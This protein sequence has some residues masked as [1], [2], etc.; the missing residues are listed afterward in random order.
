[1]VLQSK[2]VDLGKR[3][4]GEEK[5]KEEAR[6][7]YTEKKRGGRKRGRGGERTVGQLL[8]R[9]DRRGLTERS[10]GGK[11]ERNYCSEGRGIKKTWGKQL[12]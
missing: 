3:E 2:A 6:L 5:G 9:E 12:E 11:E 8:T 10:R 4:K 7:R 1:M